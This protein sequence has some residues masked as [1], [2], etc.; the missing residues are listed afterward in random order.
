MI[1][2]IKD[3]VPETYTNASGY[4]LFVV[5][6][7]ALDAN[8]EMLILSFEGVSITSSSFLNSSIGALIDK[9]GIK[10]FNR[11]KA[12]KLTPTQSDV[13]K[14]YVSSFQKPISQ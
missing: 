7:N 8:E 9:Y 10:V 6:E 11:V 1:I 14:K 5:M 13:L 12:V 2:T 4:S 3:I